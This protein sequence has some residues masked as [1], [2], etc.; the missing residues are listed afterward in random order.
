M[1]KLII[2]AAL[3]GAYASGTGAY[4]QDRVSVCPGDPDTALMEGET[5]E[6][7]LSATTEKALANLFK[8]NS[9]SK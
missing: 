8:D 9:S 4:A 5:P 3:I 1:K 7:W 2:T 6:W